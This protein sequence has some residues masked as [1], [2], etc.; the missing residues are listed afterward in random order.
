MKFGHP[1]EHPLA[2]SPVFWRLVLLSILLAGTFIRLQRLDANSLWLDE[3]TTEWYAQKNVAQMLHILVRYD[4]HPPIMYLV[5][6]YQRKLFGPSDFA[7]RLPWAYAGILGPAIMFVVGKRLLN[8]EG[9]LIASALLAFWPIH[10]WYSQEARQYA[11]LVFFSWCSLYFLIRGWQEK[12]PSLWGGF[13]LSTAGNLYT[14]NVALVWLAAESLLIL[15]MAAAKGL[16]AS[17]S[18]IRFLNWGQQTLLPFG[19][20]LLAIFVLYLPWLPEMLRQKQRLG[21]HVQV[22]ALHYLNFISQ[23]IFV[24]FNGGTP[25]LLYGGGVLSVLGLL[26]LIVRYRRE[27][28]M[29]ILGMLLLPLILTAG[30]GSGHFFAPRYLLP[31]LGPY[32]LLIAAGVQGGYSFFSRDSQR[33]TTAK[34]LPVVI[35][36]CLILYP[37]SDRY[38]QRGKEDWRGVAQYL[39]HHRQPGDVILGDGTFYGRGGD[40]RRVSW[41]L[42]YYLQNDHAVIRVEPGL[43]SKL[44]DE[45][46]RGNVWGILWH[47]SP[48]RI[49][50]TIRKTVYMTNFKDIL[51]LRLRNPHGRVWENV[52]RL[53]DAMLQL[54]KDPGARVDERLA[55]AEVY[56]ASGQWQQASAQW[57]QAAREVPQSNRGLSDKVQAFAKRL[58]LQATLV[59]ARE[60]AK[61]GKIERART[62]YRELLAKSQKEE[63]TFRILMDWVGN[64]R[65]HGDPAMAT[66]LVEEALR[67]R[68]QDV[69]ARANY[70]AAL[71]EAGRYSRA[72]KACRWLLKNAPHN[73]WGYYYLGLA[74]RN[75]GHEEKAL[76]VFEEAVRRAKTN[77][78]RAMALVNIVKVAVKM[79]A[80]STVQR[81]VKRFP[82]A[83]ALHRD[84]IEA[85]V[86]QC[87]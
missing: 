52:P 39:A 13:V 58:D 4:D 42:G 70:C 80:C 1:G 61:A 50:K 11:L 59:Q 15:V 76:D 24:E 33:M 49:S 87:R 81:W 2:A 10:V 82:T 73:F 23:R 85:L 45:S 18:K 79:H 86:A 8:R 9:G 77:D 47:Q 51:V 32:L 68:P 74:Y 71:E 43:T 55:L 72:L 27:E 67:L 83:A 35:L 36:T 25:F 69:N 28:V 38:V 56:A 63:E 21:G 19:L 16:A 37:A 14:H 66:T 17:K 53:L 20:S 60:A 84:T 30:V 48:L 26:A 64:E 29:W 3:V 6:I 65:L 7:A 41:C 44:P 22:P 75:S 78:E 34:V 46:A 57:L 54:V 5:A 40:A 62:L 31:L 12:R